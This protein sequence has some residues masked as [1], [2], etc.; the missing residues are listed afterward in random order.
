MARVASILAVLLF[1]C[2]P[3]PVYEHATTQQAEATTGSE[4][5]TPAPIGPPPSFLVTPARVFVRVDVARIRASPIGPDISSAIRSTQTWQTY[6]GSSGIDPIDSFDAIVIGAD[7]VYAQRRTILL[8][9]T[10]TDAQVRDAI[11]RMSVARG[12]APSWSDVGGLPVAEPPQALP[13]PHSVVLSAEHEVVL[14]PSDDVSRVVT[15]AHDQ[16][17]RRTTPTQPIDPSLAFDPNEIVVAHVDDPPARR[18]G[19]PEPPQRYDVWVTESPATH[20]VELRF[21]GDFDTAE[22]CHASR[23]ALAQLASYYAGQMLVRAAGLN[24]PLEALELTEQGAGLDG[25]TTFTLEEVRRALGAMALMQMSG[26]AP[27]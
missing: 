27:P 16:A 23:E 10:E 18:P 6:A 19:W 5:V 25:H 15:I 24:R 21:H 12:G 3:S 4:T 8:R 2:G 26:G 9:H 22:H 20:D 13:V 14:T 1:S 11:L 7:A 17:A